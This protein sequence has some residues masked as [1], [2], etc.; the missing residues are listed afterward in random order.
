MNRTTATFKRMHKKALKDTDT[1]EADQERKNNMMVQ[2]K[3]F[4]APR[5]S[6]RKKNIKQ[7]FF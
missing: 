7:I 5:I 3:N 4:I 1:E 2:K 6:M